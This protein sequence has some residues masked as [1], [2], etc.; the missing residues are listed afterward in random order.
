MPLAKPARPTRRGR[1]PRSSLP[2]GR[3]AESFADDL[4]TRR[5]I[6]SGRVAL[7]PRSTEI[8]P[9]VARIRPSPHAPSPPRP[10][11]VLPLPPPPRARPNPAE[12]PGLSKSAVLVGRHE[13]KTRSP[14]HDPKAR[15]ATGSSRKPP[16]RLQGRDDGRAPR[17]AGG[18]TAPMPTKP[19]GVRLHATRQGPG[20][21][22][23]ESTRATPGSV[24]VR[25]PERQPCA[26]CEGLH[27]RGAWGWLRP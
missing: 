16:G 8:Q 15:Q 1:P 23:R 3:R 25:S 7:L 2:N 11:Q 6:V 4:N 27:A 12:S 18:R 24:H 22:P 13:G 14:S 26:S 5:G 9:R 19:P 21:V 20:R 17:T 10:A